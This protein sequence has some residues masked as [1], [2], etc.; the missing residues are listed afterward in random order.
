MNRK[1][2]TL[3]ILLFLFFYQCGFK[4]VDY[5]K[6]NNFKI[7]EIITKG[8]N[9][10]NYKLKSYIK[11]VS[12]NNSNTSVNL[13]LLSNSKTLIKEKNNINE[14]TKYQL[15]ITA[16]VNYQVLNTN[17]TDNF[18]LTTYGDYNVAN[19]SSETLKNRDLLIEN[20]TRELAFQI[21]RELSKQLNDL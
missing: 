4:V 3:L 5:S 1:K 2:N 18:E 21:K 13:T 19:K 15:K 8:E 10:I 6:I 7:K 11:V 12:N 17:K 16:K 14:V 20:L 9:R